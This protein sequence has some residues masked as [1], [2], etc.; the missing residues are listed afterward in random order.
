[1]HTEGALQRTAGA[2]TMW[3]AKRNTLRMRLCIILSLGALTTFYLLSYQ[4]D[5]VVRVLTQLQHTE[6]GK[7]AFVKTAIQT[8]IEEPLDNGS[9]RDLCG[10]K[11]WTDG[12]VFECDSP[13]GGVGNVENFFMNCVRFAIEAGGTSKSYQH[14]AIRLTQFQLPLLSLKS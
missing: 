9:I 6:S 11:T 4:K 7:E 5:E 1:M 13:Q 8:P 10:N 12:L 2:A 3:P 14:Q